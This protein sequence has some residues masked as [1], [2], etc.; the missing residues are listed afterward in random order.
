MA[1]NWSQI[2]GPWDT[3]TQ[4]WDGEA[5]VPSKG[6]LALTGHIPQ[7]S[8]G[9]SRDPAA[10]S[11]TFVTTY[12]WNLVSGTWADASGTWAV[13]AIN[14]PSVAVG[15]VITISQGTVTFTSSIPTA[16]IDYY[17]SPAKTDL[18]S[19]IAQTTWA[20]FGGDWASASGY[21]EQGYDPAVAV[22]TAKVPAAASLE[23]TKSYEWNSYSGNWS[24][25][26]TS[27]NSPPNTYATPTVTIGT[28]I[29]PGVDTLTITGSGPAVDIM[30]LT[31]VPSASMSTTLFVPY[32]FE[33]H[34][35]IPDAASLDINPS[36]VTWNN[37]VGDWASATEAWNDIIDTRPSVAQTFSF[38]IGGDL[39]LTGQQPDPQHR[40][41]KFLPPVQVI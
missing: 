12:P 20:N 10:G 5:F 3:N 36:Q 27:W 24:T 4:E 2:G 23:I 6:D 8:A 34:F 18:K 21:W 31:Y 25:G 13:P 39:T 30:R 16:G 28:N 29:V 35:A 15:T 17:F 41:P 33:G 7:R 11:A 19:N 40:A 38:S 9:E 1:E 37:W 32:V 14:V 22:G 26:T